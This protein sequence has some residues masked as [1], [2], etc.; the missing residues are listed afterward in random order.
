[1]RP[2]H[3]A[4]SVLGIASTLIETV[5]TLTHDERLENFLW[6]V[7]TL[8]QHPAADTPALSRGDLP[9]SLAVQILRSSINEQAIDPEQHHP[10]DELERRLGLALLAEPEGSNDPG[11]SVA[12]SN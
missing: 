8:G 2:E 1:M 5:G 6:A 9:A 7:A 12:S 3:R 10:L 4:Y 11:D